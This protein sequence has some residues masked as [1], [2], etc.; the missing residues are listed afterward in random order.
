MLRSI[1]GGRSVG[2]SYLSY[3]HH[4][5]GTRTHKGSMA[6]PHLPFSYEDGGSAAYFACFTVL[7][8]WS[9]LPLALSR[10]GLGRPSFS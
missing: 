2:T 7:L 5:G 4:S 1:E 10:K 6:G 3:D 9:H 8:T